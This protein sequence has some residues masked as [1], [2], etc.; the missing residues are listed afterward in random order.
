[1][2]VEELSPSFESYLSEA[3]RAAAARSG[4]SVSAWLA[5]VVHDRLH[6]EA[7]ADARA[8]ES[9]TNGPS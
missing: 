3:I 9:K 8:V 6:R 7:L 1:M 4:Q 2:D 5:E